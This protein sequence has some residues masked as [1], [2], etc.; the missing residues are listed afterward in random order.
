M[1]RRQSLQYRPIR[2]RNVFRGYAVIFGLLGLALFLW[3]PMW[4]GRDGRHLSLGDA[5]EPLE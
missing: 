5:L 4:V 2:V 1:K 3:G